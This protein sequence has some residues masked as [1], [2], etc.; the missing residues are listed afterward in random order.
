MNAFDTWLAMYVEHAADNEMCIYCRGVNH[1]SF[2]SFY[3]L[4]TIH[5]TNV[6][7]IE[8][9]EIFLHNKIL[10]AWKHSFV[11]EIW[12]IYIPLT[13]IWFYQTKNSKICTFP[14]L[15]HEEVIEK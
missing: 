1:F 2:L 14:S 12:V 9:F 11:R 4:A 6:V 7:L 15:N 3:I 8:S 13:F 10:K 5:F